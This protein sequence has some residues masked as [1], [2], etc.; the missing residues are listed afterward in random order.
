MPLSQPSTSGIARKNLLVSSIRNTSLAATGVTI[1]ACEYD[2]VNDYLLMAGII[3]VGTIPFVGTLPNFKSGTI[4]EFAASPN[5][6]TGNST[7]VMLHRN[8]I[9]GGVLILLTNDDMALTSDGGATWRA[10]NTGFGNTEYDINSWRDNQLVNFHRTFVAGTD[11]LFISNDNGLTF[12]LTNFT[13]MA[14][15]NRI[16]AQTTDGDKFYVVL[17]FNGEFAYTSDEDMATAVFT[18]FPAGSFAGFTG[19]ISAFAANGDSSKAIICDVDG[20]ILVSSDGFSTWNLFDD[21]ENYFRDGTGT[22]AI[23]RDA[24]YVADISGF[25]IIGV[26]GYAAF[27]PEKGALDS[28]EIVSFSM[29]TVLQPDVDEGSTITSDGIEMICISTSVDNV[30]QLPYKT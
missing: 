3:T 24:V 30:M 25:I 5:T 28:M 6:V 9:D 2:P 11:D 23:I 12:P 22:A 21:T 13:G 8:G 27:I 18:N 20:N 16:F 14:G 19:N 1:Q 7:V 4:R 15:S 10:L 29:A 17:G 26:G